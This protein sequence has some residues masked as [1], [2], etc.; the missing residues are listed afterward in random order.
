[1][2]VTPRTRG[3]DYFVVL[4]VLDEPGVLLPEVEEL[5]AL[6]ARVALDPYCLMQSSRSVPLMPTH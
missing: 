3:C 2:S 4:S 5:G 6:E 1:L